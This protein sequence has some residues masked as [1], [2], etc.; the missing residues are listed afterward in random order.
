MFIRINL[1]ESN[2]RCFLDRVVRYYNIFSG[3]VVLC[4]ESYFLIEIF[5]AKHCLAELQFFVKTNP[6]STWSLFT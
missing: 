2:F 5:S 4:D 1:F 3:K 6:A